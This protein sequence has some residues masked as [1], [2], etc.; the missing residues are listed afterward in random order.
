M[1]YLLGRTVGFPSYLGSGSDCLSWLRVRSAIHLWFAR[2]GFIVPLFHDKGLEIIE[3]GSGDFFLTNRFVG[4]NTG[5]SSKIPHKEN[6]G[7]RFEVSI[8][9]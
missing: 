6:F 3:L 7:S 9:T 1:P 4:S 8:S 5:I 2:A